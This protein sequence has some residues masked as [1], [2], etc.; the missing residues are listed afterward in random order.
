[1]SAKLWALGSSGLSAGGGWKFETA[2]IYGEGAGAGADEALER[3]VRSGAVG[4]KTLFVAGWTAV[5]APA[6]R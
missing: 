4:V 3:S 1:L 2:D 5:V 6:G